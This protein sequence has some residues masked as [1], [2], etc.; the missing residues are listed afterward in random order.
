MGKLLKQV[1][2]SKAE[3]KTWKNTNTKMY[4]KF[5]VSETG[6]VR[7]IAFRPAHYSFNKNFVKL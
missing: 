4:A 1:K 2:L 7:D 6:K 3:Y 5:T